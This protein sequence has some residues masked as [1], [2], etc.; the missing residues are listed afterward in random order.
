V[1]AITILAAVLALGALFY[2]SKRIVLE[3]AD[4]STRLVY[5]CLHVTSQAESPEDFLLLA[6]HGLDAAKHA[7]KHEKFG[8][9]S[10]VDEAE[11]SGNFAAFETALIEYSCKFD[12]NTQ[13]F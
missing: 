1:K 7:L 9:F 8:S 10:A 3:S 13:R 2:G 5:F 4:G 12:V 11:K 6:H